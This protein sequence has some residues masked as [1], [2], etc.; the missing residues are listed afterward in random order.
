MGANTKPPARML[1]VQLDTDGVITMGMRFQYNPTIINRA[2]SSTWTLTRA[3][4][5]YRAVPMWGQHAGEQISIELFLYSRG[6]ALVSAVQGQM[7]FLESCCVPQPIS[8][9]YNMD[10]RSMSDT[11]APPICLIRV[12]QREWFVVVTS[13]NFTEEF[14]DRDMNPTQARAAITFEVVLAVNVMPES[15]ERL[16]VSTTYLEA[17]W[18]YNVDTNFPEVLINPNKLS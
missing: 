5:S 10:I 4:G 18:A 13:V 9:D 6:A 3:P 11:R 2:V 17:S 8:N 15:Q 1:L 16:E 14:F 7:R 12:G